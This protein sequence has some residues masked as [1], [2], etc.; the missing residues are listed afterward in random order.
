MVFR[1]FWISTIFVVP[2][3]TNNLRLTNLSFSS[4]TGV[5]NQSHIIP[6]LT[7]LVDALASSI[8]Q[9]TFVFN[10][11]ITG[12]YGSAN[13]VILTTSQGD[14]LHSSIAIL[15]TPIHDMLKMSFSP[16][17]PMFLSQ[18]TTDHAHYVTEYEAKFDCAHWQ[19]NGY[20]GFILLHSPHFLC[21]EDQTKSNTLCGLVYHDHAGGTDTSEY[22]L[23][24][25]NAE[26]GTCM[27][28]RH[29][30]Q[31]TWRQ[32]QTGDTNVSQ[33]WN[34]IIFASSEF[35][36]CGRNRMNGAIQAGQRAA[37]LAILT[38]RPQLFLVEEDSYILHPAL[39]E[40]N[41]HIS[42]WQYFLSGIMPRDV[43]YYSLHLIFLITAAYKVAGYLRAGSKQCN[44]ISQFIFVRRITLACTQNP[45]DSHMQPLP[46][47]LAQCLK[48][49]G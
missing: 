34:S 10:T 30:H 21:F 32:S 49:N 2:F 41:E 26:F 35:G 46:W 14:V 43:L 48:E 8:D 23:N 1:I 11:T 45:L 28:P 33:R 47:K 22:I 27:R 4:V 15:A 24:R 39:P 16:E 37:I 9:H 12:V 5:S 38:L 36:F 42:F 17:S 19:I 20:D 40:R 3:K 13:N 6:S 25:L 18:Q 31:R 7:K 29:W 44:L